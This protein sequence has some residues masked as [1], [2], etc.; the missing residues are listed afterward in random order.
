MGADEEDGM[1]TGKEE[2]GREAGESSLPPLQNLP[3]PPPKTLYVCVV[4][5]LLV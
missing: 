5:G 1:E 2:A 3:L 4:N